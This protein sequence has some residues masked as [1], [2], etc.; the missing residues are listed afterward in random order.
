MNAKREQTGQIEAGFTYSRHL[1]PKIEHGAVK[2]RF[3]SVQPYSFSSSAIW[4]GH[5]NFEKYIQTGVEKAL[6]EKLGSLQTT[7]VE[8]IEIGFDE[9]NS[10]PHGFQSAAYAATCAAF[11]I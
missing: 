2:I 11:L 1:G 9:V 5:E 4:A 10:T 7:R 6:I 3:D 8:L